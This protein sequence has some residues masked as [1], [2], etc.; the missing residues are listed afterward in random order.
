MKLYG[1]D[2]ALEIDVTAMVE[3]EMTGDYKCPCPRDIH[4]K[5]TDMKN[6][7]VVQVIRK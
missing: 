1:I 2:V 3:M 6:L 7:D 4:Y 5:I